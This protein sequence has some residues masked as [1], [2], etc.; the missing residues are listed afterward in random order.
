MRKKTNGVIEL[1]I[2]VLSDFTSVLWEYRNHLLEI[3]GLCSYTVNITLSKDAE[4]CQRVMTFLSGGYD[5]LIIDS[6]R[7]ERQEDQLLHFL[8]EKADSLR[9]LIHRNNTFYLRKF[10]E[11]REA[12]IQLLAGKKQEK[13]EDL[14]A[15]TLNQIYM[16]E[17][18]I[19]LC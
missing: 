2:G 19:N 12:P 14:L 7:Y 18:E 5:L 15:N 4:T 17:L 9:I 10:T 1:N 8:N 16:E 3:S 11:K 6:A 13:L